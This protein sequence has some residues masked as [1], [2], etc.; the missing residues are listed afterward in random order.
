[1]SNPPYRADQVGSLLRDPA[2]KLAHE[3]SLAGQYDPV[4]L[5]ALQDR[6]IRDVIRMQESIGFHAITD[7]EFRRSSFS[8]DFIEKLDGAKTP[9]HLAVPNTAGGD[10]ERSAVQGKRFARVHLRFRANCAT[11]SRS[12]S[13]ALSS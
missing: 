1:M 5:R 6:C 2:L 4:A 7:G 8:G 3:Q 12:K 11:R 9:G 10:K 13:I